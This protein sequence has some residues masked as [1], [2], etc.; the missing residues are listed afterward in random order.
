MTNKNDR[1][2]WIDPRQTPNFVTEK[3]SRRTSVSVNLIIFLSDWKI[4]ERPVTGDLYRNECSCFS[5]E[6]WSHSNGSASIQLFLWTVHKDPV[7]CLIK[8]SLCL[9][10]K[11]KFS[12]KS[13]EVSSKTSLE[14][15][16]TISLIS[17]WWK[18]NSEPSVRW[19]AK[20]R[21]LIW[22][23]IIRQV[24]VFPNFSRCFSTNLFG[25]QLSCHIYQWIDV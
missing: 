4:K 2:H 13:V 21:N 25:D 22:R 15:V 12:S 8:N 1:F 9:R 17:K 3:N 5:K 18:G 10:R 7:Y 19:W 6:K 20:Y 16:Q 11:Y 24:E 23:Q 14:I